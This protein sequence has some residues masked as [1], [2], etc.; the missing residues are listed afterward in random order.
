MNLINPSESFEDSSLRMSS[1]PHA[2][3]PALWKGWSSEQIY[4]VFKDI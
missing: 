2:N 1:V 3:E 4:T